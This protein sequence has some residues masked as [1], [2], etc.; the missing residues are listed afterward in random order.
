MKPS[1]DSRT[2]FLETTDK[3]FFTFH[4]VVDILD[5]RDEVVIRKKDSDV[6]FPK[7]SIVTLSVVH[8][9]C[10]DFTEEQVKG[11]EA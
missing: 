7:A 10:Y 11:G 5:V 3:D 4:K 9:Y 1:Y 8:R 6:C 2:V